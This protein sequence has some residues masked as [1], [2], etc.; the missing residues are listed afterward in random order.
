MVV[1]RYSLLSTAV[2]KGKNPELLDLMLELLGPRQ[3]PVI[4]APNP[5]G[6]NCVFV[7]AANSSDSAALFMVQR[8]LQ[9]LTVD[10]RRK[11]LS[12]TSKGVTIIRHAEREGKDIKGKPKTS[13]VRTLAFLRAELARL[14][15]PQ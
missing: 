14:G 13:N 1:K 3:A 5:S 11:A 12:P 9:G 7:A 4:L 10:E 2:W 8:L 15:V 6:F